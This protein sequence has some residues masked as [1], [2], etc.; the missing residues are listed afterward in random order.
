MVNKNDNIIALSQ[1]DIIT[2]AKSLMSEVDKIRSFTLKSTDDATQQQYQQP[3]ESRLNAFFRLVGLP[4]FVSVEKKDKKGNSGT[5]LS[6]D[7]QLTPGYAGKK[8][9][10]YIITNSA[11]EAAAG[12]AN[13]AK[14]LQEREGKLLSRESKIGTDEMNKFMTKALKSA[15][16]IQ[17]NI[18][19]EEKSI[20]GGIVGQNKD[21]EREVYKS[22]FPLITAYVPNGISP[23]K[24][25]TARPFLQY[26]V[27]QMPDNE[28]MLPKPFIET[29][30]RIRLISASNAGNTKEGAKNINFAEVVKKAIG[31]EK[32]NTLSSNDKD[33]LAAIRGEGALESIIITKLL[34]SL[35]QLAKKQY[36]LQKAQE[37]YFQQSN[38]TISIKTESGKQSVFGKR[39]EVSSDL[40]LKPDSKYGQKLQLLYERKAREE[41]LQSLLPT[42]DSIYTNDPNTTQNTAFMS[43]T[44]PFSS[45]ISYNLDETNKEIQQL[46]SIINKDLQKLEKL[47]VELDMMTGEF[48]GLSIP[49]VISIIIGLFIIKKQY[50]IALLDTEV[51][52]EMAKDEVLKVVISEFNNSN[53]KDTKT[54]IKKLQESVQ[55]VFDLLNVLLQKTSN[56][57]LRSG[58]VRNK[59]R[60]PKQEKPYGS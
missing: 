42:Q 52:E 12:S 43:L 56:K 19:N 18:P 41:A 9:D 38:Y 60:K 5:D 58:T 17:P 30:I 21:F 6:G 13:L 37:Q 29:V 3:I 24:N 22:L 4:M 36:D 53:E 7:R 50:L 46:K 23:V 8:F 35:S 48:I 45:L 11:K 10:N 32:Y 14:A 2:F 26:V 15:I 55:L 49:D 33:V 54:A 16:A 1:F 40:V 25:E 31:E 57:N 59:P 28:T 20:K 47:R 34:S 51:R 39:A 27:D 44:N